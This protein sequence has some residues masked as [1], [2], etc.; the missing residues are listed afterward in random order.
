MD[1]KNLYLNECLYT[2]PFSVSSLNYKPNE[3][4]NVN[5]D[6]HN[7]LRGKIAKYVNVASD[8]ITITAGGDD[9]I[10]LCVKEVFKT[11]LPKN[12]KIYKYDPSYGF[13]TELGY[14]TYSV[15]TPLVNQHQAMELYE[16]PDG[17]IIYVCNPCNPTGDIWKTENYLQLCKNYPL[18]FIIIDEAYVDFHRIGSPCDNVNTYHNLFYIRTFSK[19]FGIAGMRIGYLV[20]PKTFSAEYKFKKVLHVSKL[21]ATQ[22]LDNL[23][24]YRGIKD[25]VSS[26]IKQLGFTTT[27]NFIFIRP[28]LDQLSEFKQEMCDNGITVRYGYGNGVRITVNPYIQPNE[29]K[30]LQSIVT[31]YNQVPDIRTFYTPIEIRISLLKMLKQIIKIFDEKKWCW[32][33]DGGTRLGAERQNTIIQ[34]DDDIDIGIMEDHFT[35]NGVVDYTEF[36]IHLSKYFNLTRN[37][38]DAYYQICDKS[39]DGHPNQTIHVDIFPHVELNG[40]IVYTDKRY[41]TQI[42]GMVNATYN[43][44]DELFPLRTVEFY[45]GVIPVPNCKLPQHFYNLEIRNTKGDESKLLYFSNKVVM[46]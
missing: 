3:Y 32:W 12:K 35:K 40:C 21:H 30:Y 26:N 41:H 33:A 25:L 6:T 39:F 1:V 44:Y 10:E 24:F 4:P 20:H 28:R 36:E 16:P 29:L 22:I 42:D 37:R 31:R 18:C 2:H 45:D 8:N 17:S 23:P 34:W 19:L 14:K 13:I 15:E 38:T 5:S 46:S 43:S 7:N 11:T 9:A 27:G